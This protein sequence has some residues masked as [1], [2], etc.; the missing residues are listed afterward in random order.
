MDIRPFGNR[1]TVAAVAV[2]LASTS[3]AITIHV[4]A[5]N[6]PGPGSGTPAHPYCSIQTAIDNAADM[7]DIVVAPGSYLETI[8]FL[9]KAVTL[10]SSGGPEVTTIDG[11]QAGSVVT[12]V[13]GEGL[14]TVLDGFTITGGS[15][16]YGGGMVNDE[17]SPTVTN[18]IFSGNTAGSWGGGMCNIVSSPTVTNCTFSGNTAG[19]LGGGM[20][21]DYSSPTVTDCTFSGNTADSWGGGMF[22][23]AGSPEVTDTAFCG[24]SP[25]HIRSFASSVEMHGR[26]DMSPFCP[27]PVC[28]GDIDGDGTVGVTDFLELLA[29]WGD[30]PG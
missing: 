14:D 13:S 4:D 1:V 26:I 29:N 27:I 16:S 23:Y 19:D 28:A 25:E 21:N 18:C 7:D 2:M 20:V 24:N 8:D 5:D 3:Q 30:C 22:N 10:R 11:Q 6:C 9:G 17:S 15:G 12:C